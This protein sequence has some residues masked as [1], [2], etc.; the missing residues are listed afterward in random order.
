MQRILTAQQRVNTHTIAKELQIIKYW[1]GTSK[2]KVGGERIKGFRWSNGDRPPTPL[3]TFGN[4][5][6]FIYEQTPFF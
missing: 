6:D 5:G 3:M 4:Y 1:S 2:S